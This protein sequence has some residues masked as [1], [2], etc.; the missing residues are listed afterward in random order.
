[1]A[2]STAYDFKQNTVTLNTDTVGSIIVTGFG[3][4]DNVL[5]TASENVNII[6]Q[7]GALSDVVT[8]IQANSM[9]TISLTLLTGS[10]TNTILTQLAKR[11]EKFTMSIVSNNDQ[12]IN[13][14]GN[15]C[16]IE[17]IPDNELGKVSGER[18]W[19]IKVAQ[20][21]INENTSGQ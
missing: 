21:N 20:I 8:S 6:Q 1:M 11:N 3:D 19:V 13:T 14:V 5:N 17:K 4:G 12:A 7:E 2:T 18:A 10:P 16:Y 9:G 15:D